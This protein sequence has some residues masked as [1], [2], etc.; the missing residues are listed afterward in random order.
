M[1]GIS[2][3]GL[4]VRHLYEAF[5]EGESVSFSGAGFLFWWNTNRTQFLFN[6]GFV[7]KD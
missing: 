7:F 2:R 6:E 4:S 3:L 1:E 5:S